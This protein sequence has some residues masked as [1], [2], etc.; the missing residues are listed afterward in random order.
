VDCV[1]RQE[2][3]PAD[4]ATFST[5]MQFGFVAMDGQMEK[6]F[7]ISSRDKRQKTATTER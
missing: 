2:T 5:S 7:L 4:D 1:R 6:N 3:G